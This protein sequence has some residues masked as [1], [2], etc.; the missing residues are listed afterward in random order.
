VRGAD[1]DA[2]GEGDGGEWVGYV[3]FERGWR[4]WVGG[5]KVGAGRC[6]AAN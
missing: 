5:W 6:S 1:G 2:N 3:E 4:V